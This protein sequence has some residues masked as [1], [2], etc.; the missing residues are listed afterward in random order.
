MKRIKIL[1][2]KGRSASIF[3]LLFLLLGCGG[4]AAQVRMSL[5]ECID[6][7]L[8]YNRDL[9]NAAMEIQIASSQ[10]S[11]AFTKYFPEIS[12]SVKGFWAFDKLLRADGVIPAEIAALG[13]QFAALAGQ[14]FSLGELNSG[15]MA[16]LSA[17]QPLYAGGQIRSGNRL[18]ALQEDVAKLMCDIKEKEVIEKVSEYWWKVVQ[19]KCNLN[20]LEA[21]NRQ[22]DTLYKNVKSFVDAGVTT[23]TDLLKVTLRRKEIE[24]DKLK[25]ENGL[26][27]MRLLLAQQCGMAD[28]ELDASL[29]DDYLD[30]AP[31]APSADLDAALRRDEYM[32]A[33]KNVD[34][35]RLQLRMERGKYLPTLGVGISAFNMRLGGISEGIS[36]TL[37]TKMNNGFVMASLSVP[38][39][40][41]WGG[42]HALRARRI[43]VKRAENDALKAEEM[44]RIEIKSAWSNLQE[45]YKQIEI[46]KAS[47][48]E[49][50]ENYRVSKMNYAAGVETISELL[51]AETLKRKSEDKLAS[52]AADYHL[53][54]CKYRLKTE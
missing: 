51:D 40:G 34:A 3:A 30:V 26:I 48:D 32:L 31:P 6:S 41:W 16:E 50:A 20:T 24:G 7:A 13:P 29:P 42:S 25:V 15:Y 36:N 4:A 35:Q 12:A 37:H 54:L 53:A 33:Q 23:K 46:A 52:A 14:P 18:A 17:V 2:G 28:R 27:V 8:L 21:A 47:L 5:K 11:Q 9:R 39:S 19:L 44:L 43:Q 22:L 49:S 38:I 10:R 1:S 45:S